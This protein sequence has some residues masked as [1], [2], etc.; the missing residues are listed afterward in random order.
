MIQSI[1]SNPC[2]QVSDHNLLTAEL[3]YSYQLKTNSQ[4]DSSEDVL[5]IAERF[6]KLNFYEADWEGIRSEL[7]EHLRT[8]NDWNI[9]NEMDLDLGLVWFYENLLKICEAHT[10][11]RKEKGK[12]SRKI[13]YS[14]RK[15]WKRLQKLHKKLKVANTQVKVTAVLLEIKA[16][17]KYL[18]EDTAEKDRKGE[19]KA[20][21]QIKKNSKAFYAFARS[22]Q[23]AKAKV[24]PFKDSTGTINPDPIHTVEALKKQYSSVFSTPK[25]DKIV[26]NPAEF[27]STSDADHPHLKDIIFGP[28][29]IEDAISELSSDSAAGPDG[30]P[31]RL[32]K[33]CKTLVSHPLCLIWRKSMDE[34]FIPND[35]LLLLICPVH[36]GGLRSIPKNFRPVALTSHVIKTFERVIRKSLVRHLEV[37][38]LMA[39]GQHGFRVLRSTLT[40][41]LGHFDAILEALEAEPLA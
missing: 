11:K 7:A 18:L 21:E 2:P 37:N 24:G 3:N 9:L 40:Q 26:P 5:S 14:R 16:L 15:V 30:V 20:T 17:E 19:N 35:L 22:R 29:D 38:G 10:P 6:Q 1:E 4:S 28:S 41:L 32:L 8:H 13:P 39:D 36:K 34:G 25:P 31:A 33:E 27:F 12:N 23:R